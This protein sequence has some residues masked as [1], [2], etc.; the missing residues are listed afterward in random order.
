MLN[1]LNRG[2]ERKKRAQLPVLL[3][4]RNKFVQ[5]QHWNANKDEIFED[6][7]G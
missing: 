5:Q 1:T 7:D 3:S 6:F 4:C 2:G